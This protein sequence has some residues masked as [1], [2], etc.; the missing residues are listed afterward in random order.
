MNLINSGEKYETRAF[1]F[2]FGFH[3]KRVRFIISAA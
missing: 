3:F 1:H 2:L